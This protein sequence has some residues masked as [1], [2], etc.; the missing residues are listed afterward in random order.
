MSHRAPQQRN[1]TL[2]KLFPFARNTAYCS[3]QGDFCHGGQAKHGSF[4]VRHFGTD[5]SDHEKDKETKKYKL[6]EMGQVVQN[7][8]SKT[9][10]KKMALETI[11]SGANTTYLFFRHPTLIPGK[12]KHLWEVI[13]EEAHHYYVSLLCSA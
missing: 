3:V 7:T 12:T 13:K 4:S 2:S 11:K 1:S 6:D 5:S 8:S 9:D 10:Y